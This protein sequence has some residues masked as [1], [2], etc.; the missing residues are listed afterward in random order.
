MVLFAGLTLSAGLAWYSTESIHHVSAQRFALRTKELHTALQGRLVAFTQ[1]L[2]DVQAYVGQTNQVTPASWHHLHETLR[3][4][5]TNPG[6]EG[7]IYLRAVR[8]D[9]IENVLAEERR[10]GN[11]GLAVKPAGKR[12][13]YTLITAIEPHTEYNL[14]AMGYD[15]WAEPNRRETLSRARDTGN[16]QFTGQTQLHI[17]RNKGPIPAFLM[18]QPVYKGGALPETMEERR[19]LLVGFAGA[20]MHYRDLMNNVMPAK[21][22]DV[23]INLY[24]GEETTPDHLAF[25]SGPNLR[26]DPSLPQQRVALE[27]GGR[28][29]TL[30]YQ[31][32]DAFITPVEADYPQRVLL[33]GIAVT[34]LLFALSNSLVNRR[35][36]AEEL[37]KR[38]T[39]SLRHSEAKLRA[40]VAQAPLGIWLIAPNGQVL[41]CNRKLASFAEATP[42]EVVG[43]NLMME[44]K[45]ATLREPLQRAL[46]GESVSIETDYTSTISGKRGC[47]HFHFQP[48][49]IGDHLDHILGFVE[50][51][52]MRKGAEDRLAYLAHHDTLTGLCNRSLLKMEIEASI[53]EAARNG[54]QVAILFLDLD[55]FN[56]IN[57]SLGHS[58]GDALL[59]QVA[60]RMSSA[61]GADHL[62]SRI[63]GDE[64]VVLMRSIAGTQDCVPI[65]EQLLA[66]AHTPVVVGDYTLHTSASIGIACWPSGGSDAE[67]LSRSADM[68]MYHAKHRGRNNYQFFTQEMSDRAQSVLTLESDLHDALEKNEFRLYFQPQMDASE[69]RMIGAEALIRWHKYNGHN[70][71]DS[72]ELITPDRFIAFAEDR[73]LIVPIG[74]WVIRSACHQIR[75]WMDAG[76]EPVPVAVNISAKQFH[77]TDLLRTVISAIEDAAISPEQLVLEI[78]EST[79]M[80]DPKDAVALITEFQRMGIRTEIDDFGTGYSSLSALKRFPFHRLKIDKSFIDAIP[81]DEDDEAI[82][83]AILNIA[84]GLELEVIAEGVETSAQCQHLLQLGCSAMQGYY[85]SRPIPPE[86]FAKH[87][88]QKDETDFLIA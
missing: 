48:V 1:S 29:W 68:A 17:D 62:I 9:A 8:G 70:G 11:P 78:T 34:L 85:F 19:H 10:N 18:Y 50:D 54:R 63:G 82:V 22:A 59:V 25:S 39:N 13:F 47:Y 49:Y 32:T 35:L 41:E 7:L 57:D 69:N 21:L 65:A 15:G 16:P 37:A 31:A 80:E 3:L 55:H 77:H 81:G 72:Y 67:S 26:H 30:V 38:M 33:A 88:T 43:L 86:E 76:L 79:V 84:A 12:D 27:V 28:T 6:F 64:F 46:G 24:D 2:R 45:D 60:D 58:I 36:R 42:D 52:H 14:T 71:A 74:E 73:G 61:V 44:A 56:T 40:L 5:E 87:L 75:A 66:L 51:I 20:G 83:A 23:S 4:A 53:A